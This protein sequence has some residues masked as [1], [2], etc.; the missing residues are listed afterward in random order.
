M[1]S[2]SY[3][4]QILRCIWVQGAGTDLNEILEKKN[5]DVVKNFDDEIFLVNLLHIYLIFFAWLSCV[6]CVVSF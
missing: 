3:I 5:K 1:A 2:Q 6:W 4:C